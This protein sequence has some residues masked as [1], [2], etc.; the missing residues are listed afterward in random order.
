M[1]R[2]SP[3]DIH[4]VGSEVHPDV[5]AFVTSLATMPLPTHASAASEHF[6]RELTYLV[7][8]AGAAACL[9]ALS[10]LVLATTVE[11]RGMLLPR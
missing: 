10:A 3:T 5:L 8:I 9:V 4:P 11:H 6:A 1:R 7:L 2:A